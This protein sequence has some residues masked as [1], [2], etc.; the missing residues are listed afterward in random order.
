MLIS[1]CDW[2]GSPRSGEMKRQ[3][4]TLLWFLMPAPKWAS[5]QVATGWDWLFTQPLPP[6]TSIRVTRWALDATSDKKNQTLTSLGRCHVR[7]EM[8]WMAGEIWKN[9]RT[10]SEDACLGFPGASS[11]SLPGGPLEEEGALLSQVQR[12]PPAWGAGFLPTVTWRGYHGLLCKFLWTCTLP[13]DERTLHSL[14][15]LWAR[16]EQKILPAPCVCFSWGFFK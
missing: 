8:L 4:G 16:L 13:S 1:E 5:C 3:V 15:T 7:G 2:V 11:L 9:A 14:P 12:I 6:K 10:T